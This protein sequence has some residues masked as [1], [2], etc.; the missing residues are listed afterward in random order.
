MTD[1]HPPTTAHNYMPKVL[2]LGTLVRGHVV[3]VEI[4]HDDWCDVYRFGFCNCTCDVSIR[5]GAS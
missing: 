2:A 1:P 5:G 4:R 3:D